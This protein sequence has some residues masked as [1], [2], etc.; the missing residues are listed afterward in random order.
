MSADIAVNLEQSS[1]FNVT[2]FR[3]DADNINNNGNEFNV[4]IGGSGWGKVDNLS[5][6]RVQPIATLNSKFTP[7]MEG[8]I[9]LSLQTA[10]DSLIPNYTPQWI[11]E[12]IKVSSDFKT[13]INLKMSTLEYNV[14]TFN[15]FKKANYWIDWS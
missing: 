5:T 15:P 1:L 12:M 13:D 3:F 6:L 14:P 2:G 10:I 9:G 8:S 4:A 11:K 7:K